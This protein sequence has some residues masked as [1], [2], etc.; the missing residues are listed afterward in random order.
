[1]TAELPWL[2]GLV[3]LAFGVEAAT[4]FG[5]TLVALALGARHFGVEP[6]LAILV[7]LNV[8][9]STA[10]LAR[11]WRSV[12]RPFLLKRALPA[13][14][15]GLLA[16]TM[17]TTVLGSRGL[18]LAFGLSIVTFAAWQLATRARPPAELGPKAQWVAL[19]AGGVVHGLFATGGPL[20]VLV[21]QRDVPEKRAFR[22]TLAALWLA[23]NT[24]WLLRL[25]DAHALPTAALLLVPLALG[26]VAGELVH[27]RLAAQTF[28]AVVSLVLLAGG[29]SSIVGALA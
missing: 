22:A 10:I 27:R 26:A 1:M 18:L 21:A 5:G 13:M 8:A 6:L 2:A 4:G 28:R 19:L 7:P 15:V 20:A 14:A 23:L 12:S 29:A 3:A 24:L 25:G 17:L 16:G 11:D 9:L